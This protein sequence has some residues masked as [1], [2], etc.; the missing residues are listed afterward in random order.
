MYFKDWLYFNDHIVFVQ[1][2]VVVYSC[3][4][5]I[6][7]LMTLCLYENEQAMNLRKELYLAFTI[8]ISIQQLFF[9]NVLFF[10]ANNRRRPILGLRICLALYLETKSVWQTVSEARQSERMHSAA[11]HTL[12]YARCVHRCTLIKYM[13]IKFCETKQRACFWDPRSIHKQFSFFFCST[14]VAA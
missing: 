9:F 1:R 10:V 5:I 3:R 14:W 6:I 4:I 8:R 12:Y 7:S 2:V 13:M 11:V